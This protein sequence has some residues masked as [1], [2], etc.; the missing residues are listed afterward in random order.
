MSRQ[1]RNRAKFLLMVAQSSNRD[2][3]RKLRSFRN[4]R[5]RFP[6][7]ALSV[8]TT[9]SPSDTIP[10][11]RLSWSTTGRRRTHHPPIF[12]R[13]LGDVFV[14]ETVEHIR[15]HRLTHRGLL[16]IPAFGDGSNSDVVVGDCADQGLFSPTG[17][18][19]ESTG[20]PSTPPLF[21][22]VSSGLTTSTSGVITS[23]I[24]IEPPMIL[25]GAE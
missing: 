9:R 14:F 1:R 22:G 2:R 6:C 7:L 17:S 18:A 21:S 4:L 19:P 11:R 13:Y 3:I 25:I 15:G 24:F 23:L 20:P 16:R 5:E 10:T 8:S 12:C